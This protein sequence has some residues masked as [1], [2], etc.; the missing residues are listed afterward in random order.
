MERKDKVKSVNDN[1]FP[2]RPRFYLNSKVYSQGEKC[3]INLYDDYLDHFKVQ[4]ENYLWLER[5]RLR[6]NDNNN[7]IKY[8]IERLEQM[9]GALTK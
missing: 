9:I 2:I 6:D 4:I 3:L 8:N 5:Q 7:F 1:P